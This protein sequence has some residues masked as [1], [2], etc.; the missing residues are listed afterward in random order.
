MQSTEASSSSG[1]KVATVALFAAVVW[2]AYR[3]DGAYQR[4]LKE[5]KPRRPTV[6]LKAYT[7]RKRTAFQEAHPGALLLGEMARSPASPRARR[8]RS[9]K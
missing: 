6:V 4:W 2:I 3:A 7:A 8:T 9:A 5:L 1:F